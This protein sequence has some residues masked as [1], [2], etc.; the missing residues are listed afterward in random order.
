M[1]LDFSK[2]VIGPQIGAG[3]YGTAYFAKYSGN[4]VV[5]KK[6]KSSSGDVTKSFLACDIIKE[7]LLLTYLNNNP[8]SAQSVIGMYGLIIDDSSIYLVIQKHGV[9]LDEWFVKNPDSS[10]ATH[11]T[12]NELFYSLLTAT[13]NINSVGVLHSDIKPANILMESDFSIKFIDFGLSEHLGIGPLITSVNQY[14][15]TDLY[16]SPDTR[17]SYCSDSYSIA[18][19]FLHCMFRKYTKIEIVENDDGDDIILSDGV[20]L[21]QAMID[22]KAGVGAYDLIIHIMNDFWTAKKALE[23]DYFK[24]PDHEGGAYVNPD[25]YMYYTPINRAHNE[26]ELSYTSNIMSYSKRIIFDTD[27]YPIADEHKDFLE[28]CLKSAGRYKDK[29]SFNCL[30][31]SII[32]LRKLISLRVFK[33]TDDIG[34]LLALILY[35]YSCMDSYSSINNFVKPAQIDIVKSYY[36]RILSSP[37]QFEF[38]PVWNIIEY[39][40]IFQSSRGDNIE[41]INEFIKIMC[42]CCLLYTLKNNEDPIAYYK[43]LYELVYRQKDGVVNKL[44]LSDPDGHLSTTI[45]QYLSDGDPDKMPT[46][47]LITQIYSYPTHSDEWNIVFDVLAKLYTHVTGEYLPERKIT[48]R[49]IN[50]LTYSLQY[51]LM[52]VDSDQPDDIIKKILTVYQLGLHDNIF[53][54]LKEVLFVKYGRSFSG[55]KFPDVS[56]DTANTLSELNKRNIYDEYKSDVDP[57]FIDINDE[58]KAEKIIRRGY[59]DRIHKLKMYID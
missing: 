55:V 19:T 35:V 3:T 28:R 37:V 46:N 42:D 54:Q 22:G 38:Y 48:D 17:K 21:T 56:D 32:T 49:M 33:T 31:S 20:E 57:N 14:I 39:I 1:I 11:E 6:F 9:T 45:S 36:L 2:L 29:L 53:E 47:I 59:M 27:K 25:I 15:G 44:L 40:S 4:D 50:E 58:P 51:S 41:A 12:F 43:M 52:P 16:K 8:V 5:V 24:T 34:L 10:R 26:F 13:N 7:I 23:H 18:I 30:I